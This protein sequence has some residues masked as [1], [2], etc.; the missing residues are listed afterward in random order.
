M[1][2]DSS[3]SSVSDTDK[4]TP[5]ITE[6]EDESSKQNQ[7]DSSGRANKPSIG[8]MV[9]HIISEITDDREEDS[10]SLTI[11]SSNSSVPEPV[12]E[13]KAVKFSRALTGKNQKY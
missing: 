4:T 10:V 13:K 5:L 12:R 8:P 9:N 6:E 11:K 2:E 7:D 3:K 1:E